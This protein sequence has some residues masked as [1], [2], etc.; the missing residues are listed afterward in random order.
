MLA[1][2]GVTV[3]CTYGQTELA[4]PV[5][6]GKPGGDPNV[7][8]PFRGVGYELIRGP[9]DA[10]GEGQLVLLGNYCTTRGYLALSSDPKSA[11]Y[12]EN[13]KDR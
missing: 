7:L 4:G 1:R 8:R 11:A 2:H 5:M 12:R 9:G 10:E 13:A 3:A 6:F